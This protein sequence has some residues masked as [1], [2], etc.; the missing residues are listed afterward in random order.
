MAVCACP[1]SPCLSQRD[2]PMGTRKA[3]EASDL[4][5]V[6]IDVA[7]AHDLL[8]SPLGTVHEAVRGEQLVGGA[9]LGLD[10]EW[11]LGGV[12]GRGRG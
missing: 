4:D 12:G 8:C 9:E 2:K 10:L 11:R 1:L 7:Q 5:L 6:L 3:E